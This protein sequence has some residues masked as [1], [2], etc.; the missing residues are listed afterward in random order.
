MCVLPCGV[1]RCCL[2]AE[3]GG[4]K[5]GALGVGSGGGERGTTAEAPAATTSS[6]EGGGADGTEFEDKTGKLKHMTHV[7][8]L[9]ITHLHHSHHSPSLTS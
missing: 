7:M 1:P 8:G 2:L 4:G 3:G 6:Y 5:L 9:Y